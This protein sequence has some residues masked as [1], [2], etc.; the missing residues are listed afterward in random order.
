MALV[1]SPHH[2]PLAIGA[3]GVQ[4]PTPRRVARAGGKLLAIKLL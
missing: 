3:S 2:A 4:E 1:A